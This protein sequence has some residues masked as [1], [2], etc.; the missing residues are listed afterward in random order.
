MTQTVEEKTAEE[1]VNPVEADKPVIEDPGE[2][3]YEAILE[4]YDTTLQDFSEGEV[5]EG[6]VLQVSENSVIVDVGFKSE[7][8]I[9]AGE[10]ED[11]EGKVTVVMAW[12]DHSYGLRFTE[13]SE[14]PERGVLSEGVRHVVIPD[15]FC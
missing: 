6:K 15:L 5:I 7:G 14:I 4:A 10:F 3:D 8:V 9:S 12:G 13:S 11:E 1:K 2:V